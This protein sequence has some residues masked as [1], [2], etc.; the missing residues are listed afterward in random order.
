MEILY[1]RDAGR[2]GRVDQRAAMD[3][4][5]SPEHQPREIAPQTARGAESAPVTG[6]V[7]GRLRSYFV[8]RPGVKAPRDEKCSLHQS[9]DSVEPC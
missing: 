2:L 8:A 6:W 4:G 1:G 5:P 9:V 3:S 7:G